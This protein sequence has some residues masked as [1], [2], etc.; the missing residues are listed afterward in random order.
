MLPMQWFLRMY[1]WA[2]HPPSTAMRW[3]VGI[4]IAAALVIVGL[5]ALFGTPEWMELAPRPRGVPVVR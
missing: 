1:R 5:E 4:V 2:R 3:T